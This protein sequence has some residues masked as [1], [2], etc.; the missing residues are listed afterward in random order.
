[1]AADPIAVV[2]AAVEVFNRHDWAAL[3]RLLDPR[4]HALD[5]QAPIGIASDITSSAQYVKACRLWTEMFDSARVEVDAYDEAGEQI[6]CTARYCG[7][8][9][10]S[11][12][13]VEA[14]QFDVY[15]VVDGVIV[16]A[17]VGF[18][19]ID[20]ARAVVST[21]PRAR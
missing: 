7:V 1:M 6:V 11:G 2:R 14:R 3:E 18:R 4:M 17:L 10:A 5:H 13:P 19:S 21:E 8:G 20:E 12:I 16:E 9:G 15:R